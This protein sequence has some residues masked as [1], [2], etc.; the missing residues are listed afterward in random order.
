MN[1]PQYKFLY[2]LVEDI[3][4]EKLKKKIKNKK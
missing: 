2:D 3:P 1:T 4:Q